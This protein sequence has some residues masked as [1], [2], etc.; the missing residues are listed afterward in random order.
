LAQEIAGKLKRL[1]F[2]GKPVICEV[3]SR[4]EIYSGP[5]VSQAADLIA[6]GNEGFDLK[7][8]LGSDEVFA[9]TDLTGMHTWD[10]AFVITGALLETPLTIHDL[11]AKIENRLGI[12]RK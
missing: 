7:G 12:E 11:A 8:R 2:E 10:N 5:F 1:E 3:F 6:V 9:R 4:Q